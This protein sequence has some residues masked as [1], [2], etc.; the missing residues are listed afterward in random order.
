MSRKNGCRNS[1]CAIL[2]Y[3]DSKVEANRD[4]IDAGAEARRKEAEAR[5]AA[6]RKEAEARLER[7]RFESRRGFI[8]HKRWLMAIF[9]AVVV[10]M[11][12]LFATI[13]G[14]LP[15]VQRLAS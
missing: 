2:E 10:G 15:F 8:S 11:V 6:E 1:N 9:A 3:I 12:S 4:R 5:L 14:Y 7:E 13:N